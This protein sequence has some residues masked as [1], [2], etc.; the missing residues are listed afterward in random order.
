[1]LLLTWV[2]IPIILIFLL[3]KLFFG[4][5]KDSRE[6]NDKS[7][8]RIL[9]NRKTHE[10][11]VQNT[12][13]TIRT[14]FKLDPEIAGIEAIEYFEQET[15]RDSDTVATIGNTIRRQLVKRLEDLGFDMDEWMIDLS[16][17]VGEGHGY[18]VNNMYFQEWSN[19]LLLYKP[20][21]D[22]KIFFW[23]DFAFVEG[24]EKPLLFIESIS[25]S[26]KGT[27]QEFDIK[28]LPNPN[29]IIKREF[30]KTQFKQL[31]EQKYFKEKRHLRVYKPDT[32]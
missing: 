31:M 24:M 13:G 4:K 21:K 5:S 18:K 17:P 7:G 10:F 11:G 32:S 22:L 3:Y 12:D 19:I 28:P 30:S 14:F 1:M 20:N 29:K 6:I 25:E 23:I 26:V 8:Q 9:Y 16:D 2:I 27:F 15:A